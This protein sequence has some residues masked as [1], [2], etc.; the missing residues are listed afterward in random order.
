MRY[1]ILILAVAFI[2]CGT[3]SWVSNPSDENNTKIEKAIR[4]TINKP[5]GEL[6]KAD[7]DKVTKLYLHNYKLT[8]LKGVG[9][10]N[11]L[12]WLTLN[13]NKLTDVKRLEKLTQLKDLDLRINPDLTKAQIDQLQ[14]ALPKC[15]IW[16]NPTK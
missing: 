16:S 11:Q 10:L 15:K 3:T 1:L 2:G 9:K 12:T 13:N 14:K 8:S 6:T 4:E 7:L 5:T